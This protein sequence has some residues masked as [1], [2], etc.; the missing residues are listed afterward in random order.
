M[1]VQ[2]LMTKQV[3]SCRPEDSLETAAQLMWEHDC[4]CIPVCEGGDSGVNHTIGVVTD[5]DICMNALFR[6]KPL[7][8]LRVGDAMAK[9]VRVCHSDDTLRVAERTMRDAQI[10]RLPVVDEAGALLGM[11]SL[12][13][14]AREAAREHGSH[15]RRVTETEIGDTLAA[16]CDS[17]RPPSLAA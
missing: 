15:R 12:A 7:R 14:L 13:D 4:G 9:E 10:R 16:I 1:R 6:G 5:R 2:D 3:F 8:D 11:I 17:Q